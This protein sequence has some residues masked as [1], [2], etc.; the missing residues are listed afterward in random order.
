[1]FR[2]KLLENHVDVVIGKVDKL[3]NRLEHEIGSSNVGSSKSI[4]FMPYLKR[5]TIDVIGEVAFGMI[6]L[7]FYLKL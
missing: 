3:L 5:L 7:I 1:M 4:Q 6:Q 2:Q